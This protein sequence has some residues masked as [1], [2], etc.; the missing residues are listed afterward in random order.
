MAIISIIELCETSVVLVLFI[1]TMVPWL[2]EHSL[3]NTGK[4]IGEHV[5]EKLYRG[6]HLAV[7][8]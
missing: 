2:K 3:P 7:V 6:E 4:D 5:L 8:L 1:N